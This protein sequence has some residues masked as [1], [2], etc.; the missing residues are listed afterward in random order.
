MR[1]EEEDEGNGR[2]NRERRRKEGKGCRLVVQR[3]MYI[4]RMYCDTGL[5]ALEYL[6]GLIPD[7]EI[8]SCFTRL[9]CGNTA[10][11]QLCV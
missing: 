11:G 10:K 5:L 3:R 9:T 1:G 4:L 2:K 7:T 6:T 8:L